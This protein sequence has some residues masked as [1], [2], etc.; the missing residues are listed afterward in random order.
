RAVDNSG[1]GARTNGEMAQVRWTLQAVDDLEAVCLFIARDAPQLASIFAERAL[2]TTE[3]LV[4]F[5]NSGR[6]VPELNDPN[7]R[8]IILGNYRLIYRIVQD[9]VQIITVHHGARRLDP[10]KLS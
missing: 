3:R 4:T 6:I 5:P 8:E 9:A 10:A 7:L 1:R 2:R